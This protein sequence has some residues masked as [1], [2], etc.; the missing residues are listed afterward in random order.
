MRQY[1]SKSSHNFKSSMNSV[2]F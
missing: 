2:H 1:I